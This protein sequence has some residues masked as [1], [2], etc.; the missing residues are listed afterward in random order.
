MLEESG[1]ASARILFVDDEPPILK[2]LRRVVRPLN[3]ECVFVNSGAEALQLMN[4]N[5]FDV[6]VSD[7]K[8][9]EMDGATFLAEVAKNFPEAMR[10]VLSGYAE[11]DL[12]LSAIN[13]GRVW[14]FIHKPWDDQQLIV[15]LQH[16]ITTQQMM[17]E[18]ALL[19]R[20]VE[21]FNRAHKEGFVSFV[22]NSLPMQAIYNQIERAGPS[23]ASVFITGPSGTGKELAAEA[24][25]KMSARQDAP[26]IALNC[27]AI[28]SELMESEIFGH[29]KGAFTG[30]VGARDGAASQANGG[31]LFLDELGEMDMSLQA[32]LLRFIQTGIFQKLGGSKQEKVD[33]RFVC[34]TNRDPLEA[35]ADGKLREDLYYRLNVVALHLPPLNQREND[36]LLLANT[37]LQRF[38]EQEN[39]E[40][41]GFSSDAAAVVNGYDWPGNVRQLQNCI[42][43]VVV[44]SMG[45]LI[46]HT[47]IA[48]A[49]Q[50]SKEQVDLIIQNKK[51]LQ[52]PSEPHCTALGAATPHSQ[53]SHSAET[54]T[55][56]T[57]LPLSEVEKNYIEQAIQLCDSN[58]VKAASI[59][60]VSPSTLYR[61][62]Q[63]WEAQ[64]N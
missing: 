62:I 43:N 50:L 17:V 29:V 8:M 21:R 28:P 41:V 19:R 10:L 7:M 59:L 47:D 31:T 26:F 60:G 2:S 5:P 23:N 16:A 58:V 44:M 35:I 56:D 42:H 9:P 12:I 22:G 24:I 48:I 1:A 27:A 46:T 49:L 53:T 25:H 39:K 33:I 11:D 45:P 13:E 4:E 32:K 20:T 64:A 55:L 6:V 61:K 40:L 30:A 57:L 34:A 14:G 3:A 37:F 15:T 36:P 51:Q 38:A 52:R 18:R 63:N 54:L